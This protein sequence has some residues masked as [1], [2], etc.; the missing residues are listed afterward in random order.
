MTCRGL[1]DDAPPANRWAGVAI[2]VAVVVAPVATVG[3]GVTV[4][5]TIAVV[6]GVTVRVTTRVAAVS[7]CCDALDDAAY[8]VDRDRY[9]AYVD[10]LDDG[11][12]PL[13]YDDDNW[14]VEPDDIPRRQ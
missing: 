14:R 7:D 4:T 8:A 2:G 9:Q 6:V 1:S 11:E 3:I 10:D 5:V 12:T 13:D